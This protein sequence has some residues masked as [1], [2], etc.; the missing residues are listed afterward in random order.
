MNPRIAFPRKILGTGIFAAT[1]LAATASQAATSSTPEF[2]DKLTQCAGGVDISIDANLL[3]SVRSIYDGDKTVGKAH[4]KTVAAFLQYIPE[5]DKLAAMEL[6]NKCVIALLGSEYD[7][8]SETLE[9]RFSTR[10]PTDMYIE[11]NNNNLRSDVLLRKN[12][13]FSH[14]FDPLSIY[15]RVMDKG[16]SGNGF[17]KYN[18]DNNY[19]YS[20]G[21]NGALAPSA[22]AHESLLSAETFSVS[23]FFFAGSS[24]TEDSIVSKSV[25]TNA[26]PLKSVTQ[27]LGK[28]LY[29]EL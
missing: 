23:E 13:F 26:K 22:T 10:M 25:P 27:L 21:F 24:W 7:I 14:L 18:T 11:L 4:L 8:K 16:C 6:Y 12:G 17:D 3:G 15:Y 28:C 2:M 29:I 5:K 19:Y 9:V 20:H 1:I